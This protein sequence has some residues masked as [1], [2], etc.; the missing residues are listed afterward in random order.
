MNTTLSTV[1]LAPINTSKAKLW[2]GRVLTGLPAL[3]IFVDGLMKQLHLP[4]VIEASEKIGFHRST[5]PLLGALEI[6][7]VLLLCF[8][9]TAALGAVLLTAYLGGAVAT[10]VRLGD[11]LFTHTLF[12]VFFAIAIW[13]GLA[14]RNDRI[15]ALVA[16]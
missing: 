16:R 6:I 15:A 1:T 5:L 3:F 8:R 2:I 9:R 12:P 4:Q 10:H 14:L 13:G 7:S 11:P